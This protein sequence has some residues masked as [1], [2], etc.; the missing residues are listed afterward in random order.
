M[1][2]VDLLIHLLDQLRDFLLVEVGHRARRVSLLGCGRNLSFSLLRLTLKT[3][4]LLF[5]SSQHVETGV[6]SKEL[7]VFGGNGGVVLEV[8]VIEL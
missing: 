4:H 7:D 1:S 2:T 3:R 8:D 6:G 5:H